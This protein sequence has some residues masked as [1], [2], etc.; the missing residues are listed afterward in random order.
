MR[1]P[2]MFDEEKVKKDLERMRKIYEDAIKELDDIKARQDK[3]AEIIYKVPKKLEA[4]N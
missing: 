3:I 4:N 1:N 2:P